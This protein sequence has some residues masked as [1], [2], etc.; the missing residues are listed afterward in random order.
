[1]LGTVV[2]VLAAIPVVLLLWLAFKRPQLRI[3]GNMDAARSGAARKLFEAPG[4]TVEGIYLTEIVELGDDL[5]VGYRHGLATGQSDERAPCEAAGHSQPSQNDG[6]VLLPRIVRDQESM[7]LMQRW[8]ADHTEL[9]SLTSA[10]HTLFGF[11]DHPGGLA[12]VVELSLPS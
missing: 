8:H 7:L 10:D 9:S 12:L 11:V 3:V 2:F 4:L 5:L 1:V 6:Q